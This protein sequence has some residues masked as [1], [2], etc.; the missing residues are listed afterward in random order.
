MGHNPL[1]S[2]LGPIRTLA[3]AITAQ[4]YLWVLCKT[5]GHSTRL[6]PRL[7]AKDNINRDTPLEH[8]LGGKLHCQSCGRWNVAIV[9]DDRP[10]PG[11][12]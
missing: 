8:A 4:R 2:Y 12:R 11:Y 3:D 7:L 1:R 6:D 5:C 9:P 10:L